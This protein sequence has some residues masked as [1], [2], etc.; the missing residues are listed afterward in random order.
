M[1]ILRAK[2]VLQRTLRRIKNNP[3]DY[4]EATLKAVSSALEASQPIHLV[5]VKK[6]HAWN[7]LVNN[8]VKHLDDNKILPVGS[9]SDDEDEPGIIAKLL[10]W[11]WEHR[12]EILKF[13]LA[14][15]A[16]VPM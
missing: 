4:D 16:A 6:R 5:A 7:K 2:L 1:N 14:I 3:S 13:V 8:V 10:N 11:M 15:F 12:E 9:D